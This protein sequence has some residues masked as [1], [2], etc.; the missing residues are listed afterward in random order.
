MEFY[1]NLLRLLNFYRLCLNKCAQ[2]CN[3]TSLPL[4]DTS[5]GQIAAR[6]DVNEPAHTGNTPLHSAANSGSASVMEILLECDDIQVNATNPQCEDATPM[7]LA[8]MHGTLDQ[9]LTPTANVQW[10][11]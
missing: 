4:F 5:V 6:S 7:H 11:S 3:S 8:V 1:G 2:A 9:W 10:C